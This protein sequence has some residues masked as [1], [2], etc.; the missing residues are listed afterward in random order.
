MTA[1]GE[2]DTR[3]T[4]L[5]DSAGSGAGGVARTGE[6][7]PA[8]QRWAK[9]KYNPRP[10]EIE[11]GAAVDR[12][13]AEFVLRWDSSTKTITEAD[14]IGIADQL[15]GEYAIVAVLP[16]SRTYPFC[17]LKAERAMRG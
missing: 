5:R 6:Y 13:P 3:I 1:A 12:I 10:E 11:A 9:V 15:R 7:V 17:H 2:L 16:G 14:R 8:F 4:I